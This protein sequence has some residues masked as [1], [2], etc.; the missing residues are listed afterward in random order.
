[1]QEIS[2]LVGGKAGDGVKQSANSIARAFNRMGYSV[3]VYEDYPSIIRGGHNFS[4]I[5]ASQKRIKSHQNQIDIVVAFNRETIDL[6]KEKMKD[7]VVVIFDS[8]EFLYKDGIGI[9]M[10]KIAQENKLPLIVRNS[11]ALGALAG[12]AGINFSLIKDVIKST[13]GDKQEE[14]IKMAAV[15]C[16]MAKKVI[17]VQKTKNSQKPLLT[18]NE[19]I[20]LGAVL[21]GLKFYIA[22]PMT[23]ATSILHFLAQNQ[24]EL[25]I[26]TIQPENEI[27][28]VL[29]AEGCAYAGAKSMIGTSGGGF[30]LMIEAL[31]MAGQAEIPV[32]FVLSQRPAPGTGVPTY[33]MQGDLLFALNAGHGDFEKIVAAPADADQAFYLS[34]KLLNLAWKFQVPTILLSDKHLSESTFSFQGSKKR[35]K[36]ESALLWNKRGVYKRYLQTKNGISPLAFAGEKN[37]IVK[38]TS[39]A[40]DEYGLTVE[41]SEMVVKMID[42]RLRKKETIIKEMK[43]EKVV[44]VYGNKK[45]ENALVAWGS[46]VGAAIEAAQNLNIKLIQPIYL[47][48][49]PVWAIEKELRGVKNLI[50]IETNVCGQLARVLRQNGIETNHKI[51]KYDA[52]PFTPLELEE[53]L[54]K[55]LK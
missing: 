38:S 37:A 39:Y 19:A 11:V 44:E 17:A 21:G 2:I 29:M 18:G 52:R 4:I 28:A 51:L 6:H 47:E 9:E 23:P 49:F 40:H 36:N 32:M 14:N 46:S 1:M 27:S 15:G 22:Y 10:T 13:L 48:P 54:C 5:R 43:K 55:I 50:N 26:K 16:K 35:I 24:D 45:S 7:D 12:A 8:N 25:N 30:A 41:K 33:S 31:S 20:A 3:F 34:A 53:Q 42:K